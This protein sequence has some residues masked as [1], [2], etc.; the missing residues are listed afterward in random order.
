MTSSNYRHKLKKKDAFT[1]VKKK[2][3]VELVFV[4]ILTTLCLNLPTI[5]RLFKR[6]VKSFAK[7][8]RAKYD[9][10]FALLHD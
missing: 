10:L 3:F 2:L 6:L 9:A 4:L 8:W 5:T 7:E 1:D